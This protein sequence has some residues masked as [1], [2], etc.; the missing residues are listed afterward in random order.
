[1]LETQNR[2]NTKTTTKMR[3]RLYLKKFDYM[4]VDHTAHDKNYGV[5]VILETKA[6]RNTGFFGGE[7]STFLN[8]YM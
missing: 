6:E 5:F 7:I 4:T 3:Q 8:M 2:E 1:M